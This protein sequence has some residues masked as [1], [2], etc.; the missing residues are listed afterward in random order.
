M[1]INHLGA[2]WT[3]A[4]AAILL[5]ASSAQTF[6]LGVKAAGGSITNTTPGYRIHVF[7]NTGSSTFDVTGSGEVEVLVVGGGGAG[8]MW[9]GGGGGAGGLI[10]SNGFAVDTGS[11]YTVIVGAGGAGGLVHTGGFGSNSVFASLIA[12]GGGG[13]SSD[14]IGADG[15]SGGGGGPGGFAGG[16]GTAFAPEAGNNGGS[17]GTNIGMVP[18]YPC[19]AGGGGGAGAPGVDGNGTSTNGAD[20]G[21]GLQYDISGTA[22]W[23]AGGGGGGGYST[24]DGGVGGFGGGGDGIGESGVPSTGGGGGGGRRGTGGGRG[25]SGTVIVRYTIPITTYAATNILETSAWL[26]GLLMV[27]GSVSVYWGTS[28]PGETREG[29]LGTNNLG[30]IGP[31]TFTCQATD[32]AGDV[33]YYYRC[34]VTNTQGESWGQAIPFSTPGSPVIANLAPTNVLLN[35]AVLNGVLWTNGAY[36][37]TAIVYWGATDGGTVATNWEHTNDFGSFST[38][39]SLSTNID[40][41]SPFSRYYYRFYATNSFGEMWAESSSVFV[42]KWTALALGGDKTEDIGGYRIHTFTNVTTSTLSIVVGGPVETLV[43]AGGG[44]GGGRHSGG[45]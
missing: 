24:A 10:Y 39:A 15:A 4:V 29:W 35:S 33:S 22:T 7:T 17:G 45:G 32:L 23:Y 42:T 25:G 21:D 44:G 30:E 34:Y 16:T 37:A 6:A 41:L 9:S 40:G 36:T 1:R 11:N 5:A 3:A 43:V 28:D 2:A 18:W 26:N 31:G 13:G 19:G 20:G 27:N 8:A 12:H 38:G 14:G